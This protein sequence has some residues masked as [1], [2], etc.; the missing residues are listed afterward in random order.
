MD[1]WCRYRVRNFLF[2]RVSLAHEMYE[3]KAHT[4]HC[5]FTSRGKDWSVWRKMWET[6]MVLTRLSG[7]ICKGV[8]VTATQCDQHVGQTYPRVNTFNKLV[9]PLAPSP[10]RAGQYICSRTA[11]HFPHLVYATR[12]CFFS[13]TYRSTSLRWTV[14]VPPQSGM[15]GFIDYPE[16]CSLPSRCF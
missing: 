10:L 7:N 4:K 13:W 2:A 16:V 9:F 6:V 5:G 1:C 11:G 14:L 8:R 3:R 12:M 15:F